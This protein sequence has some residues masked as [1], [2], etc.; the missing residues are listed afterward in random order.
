MEQLGVELRVKKGVTLAGGQG[1]SAVS[2]VAEW[3]I[4]LSTE[5]RQPAEQLEPERARLADEIVPRWPGAAE[6]DFQ[7]LKQIVNDAKPAHTEA[8]IR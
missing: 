5:T 6:T 1:G 2:A 3:A 8:E 7:A 4:A